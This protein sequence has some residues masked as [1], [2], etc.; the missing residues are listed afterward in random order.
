M[1]TKICKSCGRDLPADAFRLTRWGSPA[2]VCNA[3]QTEK[4]A[5]TRYERRHQ[6]GGANT[7]PFTTPPWILYTSSQADE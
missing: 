5:Q 2:N 3:C 1:E 4:S 6:G 7:L